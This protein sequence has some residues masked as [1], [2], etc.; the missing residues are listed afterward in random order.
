MPRKSMPALF[1][2]FAAW[3]DIAARTTE[4]MV[5]SSQVIANRTQRMAAATPAADDPAEFARMWPEK[6]AATHASARAVAG[7]ARPSDVRL[8]A[9]VAIATLK[10]ANAYA[11]LAGSHTPAQFIARQARLAT[12]L[13]NAAATGTRAS[14]RTSKIAAAALGPFHAAATGSAIRHALR[15]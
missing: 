4:M 13:A 3:M 14:S 2:P 7:T 15:R 8:G 10:V 5:A 12:A 1:N 11:A 9:D 6:V